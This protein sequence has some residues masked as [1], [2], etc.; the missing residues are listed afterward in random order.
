MGAVF[1][2]LLFSN[3]SVAPFKNFVKEPQALSS[4]QQG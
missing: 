1:I 3:F 2:G 4:L